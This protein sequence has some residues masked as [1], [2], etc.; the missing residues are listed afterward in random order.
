[1]P[2]DC[3]EPSPEDDWPTGDLDDWPFDDTSVDVGRLRELLMKSEADIAAGRTF[4]EDEIRALYGL[5]RR[6]A[7]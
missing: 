2:D 3:H 4:G 1:M 6:G 5:P 7:N